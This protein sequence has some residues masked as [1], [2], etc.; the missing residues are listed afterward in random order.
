MP[1]LDAST[2]VSGAPKPGD[3][4]VGK[5]RVERLIGSGGMGI[6][7]AATHLELQEM[8]AIKLLL[9]QVTQAPDAV[10]RFLREA[11]AAIKIHSEHVVRIL[12]VGRLES[13][14]PYMVMEYLEGQ[15]LAR[16]VEQGGPLPLAVGVDYLLQACEALAEAHALGIVHRDLKPA[17]LFLTQHA[18]GAPCIKV[19]DFGISKVGDSDRHPMGKGIG[20]GGGHDITTTTAILGTPSYMSPEQ[21]R[22]TRDVDARSDIWSLGAILYAMLCGSPPYQGESTADLCAKIIRDPPPSLRDARA[23]A[24]EGLG[25]AIA[26]CL[27]KAPERRFGNVA[28]LASSLVEY[29]S[30]EARASLTQILSVLAPNGVLSP[31]AG[32]VPPGSLVPGSQVPGSGESTGPARVVIS[33]PGSATGSARAWEETRL[34]PGSTTASNRAARKAAVFALGAVVTLIAALV[35]GVVALRVWG[36]S[37][38]YLG[39]TPKPPGG[40]ASAAVPVG[41]PV[42]GPV[43]GPMTGPIAE[44]VHTAAIG[45][46]TA[47]ASAG[48]AAPVASEIPTIPWNELPPAPVVPSASGA[49]AISP[50]GP[51]GDTPKTS[52]TAPAK[53]SESARP[54]RPQGP[55][56]RW[57]VR[58]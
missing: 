39:D 42:A 9:P 45:A 11:R 26:R 22:S 25:Y 29:G 54:T 51:S 43:G 48:T 49:V 38:G 44:P 19:L 13:G 17:N 28:E 8:V 2:L 30:P 41:G 24:P 52:A 18:G 10:A 12:D 58:K 7:L 3:V 32:S 36:G 37:S 34:P 15:D 55:S 23:D 5:Y 1:G 16:A 4:L 33:Y 6:V 47:K 14:A 50:A 21:M 31:K 40:S 56:P 46:S 35:G 20:G 27:E 57:D 53:G